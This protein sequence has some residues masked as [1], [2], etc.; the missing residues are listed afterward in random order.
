MKV[1]SQRAVFHRL[2]FECL[3]FKVQITNYQ[4]EDTNKKRTC[5]LR[6]E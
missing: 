4:I 6:S 2:T 1:Y 5:K 3:K